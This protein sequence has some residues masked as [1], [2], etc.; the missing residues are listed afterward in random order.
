VIEEDLPLIQVGQV[1][2][3]YVDALPDADLTGTI[4]HILPSRVEGEDR[5]LYYVILK[6]SEVPDELLE[7]M[8]LDASIIIDS[9]E[10][11][12][13]LP[14][15][16]IRTGADGNPM[17]LVWENG[18]EVERPV[19]LGLRGDSYVEILSGLSEGERVVAR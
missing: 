17:V 16:V 4:S 8:N 13:R 14:R 2:D 7:G 19:E 9:R 15:S 5:P 3:L 12:L 11:V 10:D 18:Q 1:A 6:L